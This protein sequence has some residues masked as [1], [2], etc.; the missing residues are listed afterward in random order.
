MTA[1]EARI[2]MPA[3]SAAAPSFTTRS[4]GARLV[5]WPSLAA[6]SADYAIGMGPSTLWFGVPTT[7]QFFRWYGGTTQAAVLTGGGALSLTGALTSA[8]ITSSADISV[9]GAAKFSG[10]GSGLSA[11]NAAALATGNVNPLRVV[12]PYTGI[13]DIGTL[14][15]PLGIP[16]GTTAK[17]GLFFASDSGQNTGLRRE[18]ENTMELVS[19]GSRALLLSTTQ[20]FAPAVSSQTTTLF[21]VNVNVGTDGGGILR[22][23]SSSIRY[24]TDVEDLSDA[25]AD[26]V[27]SL[28]PVWFRSLCAGDDSTHSTYGLIAEEVAEIDPRLVFWGPASDDRQVPEGVMYDRIVPHLINIIKRLE[29]R[30]SALETQ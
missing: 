29:A 8:G 13:D 17:P 1:S 16:D 6:A 2:L 26:K 21:S 23:V 11:L 5:L 27:L 9:S 22:R 18:S 12:G 28:R 30:V 14:A 20:F 4:V 10:N 24:K 7:S 25:Y 19:A 15:Q 3:S